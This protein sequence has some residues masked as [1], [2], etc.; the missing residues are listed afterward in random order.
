MASDIPVRAEGDVVVV[1]PA[2]EL[3]AVTSPGLADVLNDILGDPD[4]CRGVV[5]DLSQV[6][7][8]DSRCIGVLVS[9]YRQARDNGMG[10]ALSAPQRAVL[11]LFMIA[12]IDQVIPIEEDTGHAVESVLA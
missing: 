11:R 5:I 9:S 2:G 12:G 1:S 10:L 4:S 3:D 8:C 6:T 7:F